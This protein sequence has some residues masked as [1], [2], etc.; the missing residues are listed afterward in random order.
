MGQSL[1]FTVSYSPTSAGVHNA[2]ITVNDNRSVH[3]A[4]ITANCI[5]TTISSCS[6]FQNFDAV[7]T[8]N[9]PIDWATLF[10][11]EGGSI[12]TITTVTTLPHSAPNCVHIYNGMPAAT[13]TMLVAPPISSTIPINNLRLRSG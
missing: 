12:P 7:D 5:D 4:T 2:T 10:D 11:A 3:T 6:Y 9:L 13:A 8:P 1:S